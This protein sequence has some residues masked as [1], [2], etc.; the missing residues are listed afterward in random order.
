MT[1]DIACR[2]A[3]SASSGVRRARATWL[4]AM[5]PRPGFAKTS[6]ASGSRQRV[7]VVAA[8]YESALT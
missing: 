8:V 3:F 7:A 1:W 4:T 2:S 6:V 5:S